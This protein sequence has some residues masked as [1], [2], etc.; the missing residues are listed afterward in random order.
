MT[1][2]KKIN[3]KNVKKGKMQNKKKIQRGGTTLPDNVGTNGDVGFLINDMFGMVSQT[4]NTVSETVN[5]ID[6][7]VDLDTNLGYPYSPTEYNAPG[8]NL[9]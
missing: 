2:K 5:L 3:I 7:I 4:F 9:T 1:I 6:Y 8:A